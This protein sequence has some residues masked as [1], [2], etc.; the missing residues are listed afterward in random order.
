MEESDSDDDVELCLANRLAKMDFLKSMSLLS[1][2][3]ESISEEDEEDE[4]EDSVS[5]SP[6]S[7]MICSLVYVILLKGRYILDQD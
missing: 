5:V 6:M 3:P 1:S 4:D 2:S 7:E